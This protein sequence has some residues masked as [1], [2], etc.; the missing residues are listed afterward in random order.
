MLC[1]KGKAAAHKRKIN[2]ST[3]ETQNNNDAKYEK[4]VGDDA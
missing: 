1:C 4:I 3:T 2:F